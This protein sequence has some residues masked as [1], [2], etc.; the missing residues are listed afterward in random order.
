[1]CKSRKRASCKNGTWA[2][3]IYSPC[4]KRL[5]IPAQ[6]KKFLE[7]NP[8]K[9]CDLKVTNHKIPEELK[10][11]P[12]LKDSQEH[13][14]NEAIQ[15]PKE[16]SRV[17][18]ENHEKGFGDSNKYKCAFCEKTMKTKHHMIDHERTHTGWSRIKS[19]KSILTIAALPH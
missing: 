12:L 17:A 10:S 9:K 13:P 15:T 18:L 4:G 5:R 16:E 3:E 6:F 8:T 14:K 1:M 7:N 2:V 11:K 19:P